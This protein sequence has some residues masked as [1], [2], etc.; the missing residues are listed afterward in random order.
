M[1][2]YAPRDG[3]KEIKTWF[4]F[5]PVTIAGETRWLEKV[6]VVYE[7][8]GLFKAWK[9]RFADSKKSEYIR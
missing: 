6:T 7:Y 5:L 4:A 3:D 1:R 2:W 8:V 9:Q